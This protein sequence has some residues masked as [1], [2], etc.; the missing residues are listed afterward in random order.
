[1]YEFYSW[2]KKRTSSP[3]LTEMMPY[4][5]KYSWPGNMRELLNFTQRLSFFLDDYQQ[6]DNGVE[7]LN[8]IAPD[9]KHSME[10]IQVEIYV[11]KFGCKK[12]RW[13]LRL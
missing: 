5:L 9:L 11:N 2:R 7:L 13:L 1:M 4:L 12:K 10:N 8:I 3:L 6:G